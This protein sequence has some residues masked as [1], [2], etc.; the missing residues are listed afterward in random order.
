[1][2]GQI[3]WNVHSSNGDTLTSWTTTFWGERW[4]AKLGGKNEEQLVMHPYYIFILRDRRTKAMLAEFQIA[5]LSQR[6]KGGTHWRKSKELRD[7]VKIRR[8]KSC[9][10]EH[11]Y[12]VPDW[13]LLLH[14]CPIKNE[15][16][17][18]AVHARIF[19]RADEP[20]VME[21][22]WIHIK[23]PSKLKVC[24]Q[25]KKAPLLGMTRSKDR[26]FLILVLLTIL[27]NLRA[28][29]VFTS[30]TRPLASATAMDFWLTP[31]FTG[32]PITVF[33]DT[34]GIVI[35]SSNPLYK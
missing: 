31:G 32:S 14:Q 25:G 17:L 24:S 35:Y 15:E 22:C 3:F 18:V 29:I 10:Q 34:E 33:M 5:V 1:M 28:V 11:E 23:K 19:W 16:I 4:S 7:T 12:N 30:N 21:S 27:H 20:A 26:Y 8:Q 2:K 6:S 13:H 9:W